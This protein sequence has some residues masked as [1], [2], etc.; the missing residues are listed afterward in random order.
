MNTLNQMVMGMH[1]EDIRFLKLY[2]LRTEA[3][4]NRKD[5]AFFDV[6]RKNNKHFD[7]DEAAFKLYGANKNAFYRMKNRLIEEINKSL[8]VQHVE[9]DETIYIL[10]LLSISKF[11]FSRNQYE[12][13]FH[14]LKK[15]EKKALLQENF[16]LLDVIYGEFIKLSHEIFTINP[17]T[18]I[19]KRK[20]NRI[21][22]NHL[23]EID[24]ILSAVTYR[25]KIS[26]NF[27]S[28]DEDV[29]TLL[30]QTVNDYS[31]NQT[32]KN[33]PS[34]R[35]RIYDA[36][37]RI[38]LSKHDYAGLERYV[39]DTYQKFVKEHLFNKA[40]HDTKLQM[41]TYIV[42]SLFKNKKL[43]KSLAY[44][45]KLHEAMQAYNQILYEKYLFF[46]YNS[47]V[48][49]YSQL[50]KNKAIE[51]LENLKDHSQLKKNSY[52]DFFIYLNLSVLYFD[53]K[54]FR[55]SIKNLNKFY[56]H[57]AYKNADEVMKFKISIAELMIRFE[58]G[59]FDFLDQ[60]I[61]HLQK[62]FKKLLAMPE[63]QRDRDFIDIVSRL[64]FTESVQSDQKL[65]QKV[66]WFLN[67]G[68]NSSLDDTE[69]IAYHDWLN[70]HM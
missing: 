57:A 8:I 55:D 45:E 62:E 44:A 18:Y 9:D 6:I 67:E 13:A 52:Y 25:I 56:S 17:E 30:Q 60:K 22:L 2:A 50:D 21:H 64:M 27:S 46:Y 4:P 63:Y 29:L 40:N 37:S 66:K 5:I 65:H 58:L 16:D 20:E 43:K 33:S 24:D 48:I 31:K 23:R 3:S 26:Q 11:Y 49:N 47:L 28:G 14:F 69:I 39:L 38:L 34:L 51:I 12:V 32:L 41:L 70:N 7:E 10:H 42:N 35:F 1:K 53:Q 54:A 59:D 36:V 61:G 68:Q 15:A 19:Q